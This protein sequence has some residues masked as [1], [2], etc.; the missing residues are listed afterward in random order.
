[1][2]V[3]LRSRLGGSFYSFYDQGFARVAACAV[4]VALADPETNAATVIAAARECGDQGVAI[5][6]F[7]E[8]C[9]T[10]YAIDDLLLQD[11]L[12]DAAREA[13]ETVRAASED[14]LPVVVVGVPL[15]TGNRLYNLSLIHISEPTRP[16]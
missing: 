15:A 16:Y 13:V 3:A 2:N 9:L 6:V 5:A 11:P 8:L 10:G 4:P 14:L 1:M 12:L 7:P